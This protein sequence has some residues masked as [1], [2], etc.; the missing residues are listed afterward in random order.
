MLLEVPPAARRLISRVGDRA[1]GDESLATA[2]G[3]YHEMD[4]GFWLERAET[5]LSESK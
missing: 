4:M 2:I 1:N 5:Q 3:M